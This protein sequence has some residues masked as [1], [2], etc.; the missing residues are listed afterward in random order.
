MILGT[1]YRFVLILGIVTYLFPNKRP[2]DTKIDVSVI[3]TRRAYFSSDFDG[4]FLS[5][6]P[7]EN[8]FQKST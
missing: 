6:I 7:L 8:H 3:C 1:E 4:G 5:L 2:L